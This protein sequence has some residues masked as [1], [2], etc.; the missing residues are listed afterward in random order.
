VLTRLDKESNADDTC[1]THFIV[2]GG[3]ISRRTAGQ[4]VLRHL[5][6]VRHD[7]F[8]HPRPTR[9]RVRVQR[10]AWSPPFLSVCLFL[11]FEEAGLDADAKKT[12]H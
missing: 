12:M 3:P 8:T 4:R 1:C 9:T 11:R 6:T 5:E 7:F 10:I 2:L